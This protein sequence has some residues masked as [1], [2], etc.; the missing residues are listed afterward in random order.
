MMAAGK[1]RPFLAMTSITQD[2]GLSGVAILN[3]FINA[4]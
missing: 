4:I 2:Q 1:V 3:I